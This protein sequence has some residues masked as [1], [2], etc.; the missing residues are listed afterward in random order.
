MANPDA[1]VF[2]PLDDLEY[3][4]RI[5]GRVDDRCYS[6]LGAWPLDADRL[7]EHYSDHVQ[8]RPLACFGCPPLISVALKG[9]F[10]LKYGFV[11]IEG[12]KVDCHEFHGSQ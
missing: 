11:H 2:F 4:A 12:G 7:L 3:L 9:T 1:H 10:L 5:D 6:E 8:R